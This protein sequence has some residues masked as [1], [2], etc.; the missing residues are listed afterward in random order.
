MQ[1]KEYNFEKTNV[2]QLQKQNLF[3]ARSVGA[4]GKMYEM[5]NHYHYDDGMSFL[6]LK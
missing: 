3:E 6:P 4:K 5:R 1:T 2:F